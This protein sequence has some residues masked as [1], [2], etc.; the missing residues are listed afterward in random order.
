MGCLAL[1]VALCIR[2]NV[3]T[4]ALLYPADVLEDYDAGL[5]YATAQ[6]VLDVVQVGLARRFKVDWGDE[7]PVG[8]RG[9]QG[10][11]VSSM[12]GMELR[13]IWECGDKLFSVL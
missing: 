4:L 5:E 10:D 3:L 1:A 6:Q 12:A 11:R 2:C 13:C 8:G 7:Y 9:V